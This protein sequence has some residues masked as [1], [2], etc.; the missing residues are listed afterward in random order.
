MKLIRTL[1]T[2]LCALPLAGASAQLPAM[3]LTLDSCRA[4][5]L[6]SNKELRMADAKQC[7]ARYER[8]AALTHYLPRLAAAGGYLHTGRELSLLNGTQKEMLGSP[9]LLGGTL[10]EALRTDTR[11]AGAALLLTQPLYTGGKIAASGHIARYAEQAASEETERTR[12][13]V[14]A[15]VDEAY[16]QIVLLQARKQLAES[17]LAL[18][19]QVD[20]DLS[21]MVDEGV[22]T[23]ADRLSARVKVNEA[24]VALIQVDNGLVIAQMQ[25]CRLCGLPMETRVTPVDEA[26]D[27]LP[28]PRRTKEADVETALSRRPELHALDRAAYIYKERIRLARAEFLPTVALAGGYMASNPSLF[29]SYERRFKGTWAVGVTVNIPLLTCGERL[30]KV[31]AARA[32]ALR[33]RSQWEE[34]R[35]KVELEVNRCRQKVE[36]AEER[37]HAAERSQEEADENLRTATL[38]LKEGVIPVSNV[39]EA[40][41]A[42][43]SAHSTCITAQ[44][45]LRL[46]ALH[47]RKATGTLSIP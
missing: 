5:A 41:T 11:D 18:T 32:E 39:L 24:E 1:L 4:L 46:A 2:A 19:R 7:A 21:R 31:K 6:R 47:L 23:K 26:T 37:L 38:G 33:A 13:E 27:S 43:L 17:Y 10:V 35:E 25:L 8:K 15:D 3:R 20:G 16:W 42:W 14:I 22:A 45:D 12:Q 28:L 36:E 44:I 9:D 30:Y 34:A 29:N 40:Q